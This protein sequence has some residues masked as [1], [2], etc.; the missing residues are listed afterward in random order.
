MNDKKIKNWGSIWKMYFVSY[1]E[2]CSGHS[3]TNCFFCKD[4]SCNTSSH[5]VTVNLN[6]SH[7]Q[8]RS[9]WAAMPLTTFSKY[10]S[11]Y[12][13][14]RRPLPEFRTR[15]TNNRLMGRTQELI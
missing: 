2:E 7:V 13:N 9:A 5:L 12:V 15:D 1:C 11:V 3:A 10:V 8:F 6:R 4:W 14:M